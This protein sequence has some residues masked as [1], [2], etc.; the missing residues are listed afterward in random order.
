MF[1]YLHLIFNQI[2][3]LKIHLIYKISPNNFIR[4]VDKFLP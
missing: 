1:D 4:L 3:L 2:Y